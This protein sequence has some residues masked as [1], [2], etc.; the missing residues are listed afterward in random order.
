MIDKNLYTSYYTYLLLVN[1]KGGA[2]GLSSPLNSDDIL[3]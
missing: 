2:G 1:R 3:Q